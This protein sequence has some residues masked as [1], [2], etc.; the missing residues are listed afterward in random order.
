MLH[1]IFRCPVNVVVVF[2]VYVQRISRDV[3]GHM[4]NIEQQVVVHLS[5]PHMMLP[6]PQ[7]VF[8]NSKLVL[9]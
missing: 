7:F 9:F 5:Y 4:K 8:V 2:L 6:T 1:H 3:S